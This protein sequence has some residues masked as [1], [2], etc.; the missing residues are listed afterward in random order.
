MY[1][2]NRNTLGHRKQACC[3]PKREGRRKGQIRS[4]GLTDTNYYT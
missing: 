3:Y 4:M 2:Q 1:I